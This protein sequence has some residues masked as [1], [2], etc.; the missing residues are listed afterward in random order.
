[1]T[2]SVNAKKK[3][4]K[5]LEKACK[6]SAVTPKELLRELVSSGYNNIYEC[7]FGIDELKYIIDDLEDAKEI[8]EFHS[9]K[10]SKNQNYEAS[11]V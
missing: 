3:F 5:M 8:A 10:S 1:M 9:H 4:Q 11:D 2:K 7:E 6:N